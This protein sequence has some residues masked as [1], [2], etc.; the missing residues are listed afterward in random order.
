[1]PGA[2]SRD[3]TTSVRCVT[4]IFCLRF[5]S[6]RAWIETNFY[7]AVYIA[8]KRI[9]FQNQRLTAAMRS[10][11]ERA[12]LSS[13]LR[14]GSSNLSGRASFL[15]ANGPAL[16]APADLEGPVELRLRTVDH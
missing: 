11:G 3:T 13:N 9:C 1:M 10:Y 2:V 6:Q 12:P 7:G 8:R 5:V 16:A 4:G 14:V 15:G